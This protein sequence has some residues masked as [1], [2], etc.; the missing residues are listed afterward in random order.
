MFR[1]ILLIAGVCVL[2][3]GESAGQSVTPPAIAESNRLP[4]TPFGDLGSETYRF[5]FRNIPWDF[6]LQRFAEKANLTLD[7]TDLPPDGF[8]YVD[9]AE[10]TLA[11]ALDVINGYLLPRGYV[12]LRRNQFLVV[13]KADNPILPNMIPTVAVEDLEKFGDHELLRTVVPVKGFKPS[14]VAEQIGQFLGAHGKASPVDASESVLLQG[15]GKS[16]RVAVAVLESS[17]A[18]PANDE[19]V[20]RAF[21]LEN[22]LAADAE[23]QIQKLFGVGSNPY[24]ASLARRDDYYRRRRGGDDDKNRPPQPTPLL[25]NLTMNMKISSLARTNSLLVTAPPSAVTLV[26]SILESLDVKPAGDSEQFLDDS[27]P[28]LRVYTVNEADEDDVAETVNAIM[29]GVVINEDGRHDSVHIYATP[30]EHAEVEKLIRIIDQGGAGGGVEVIALYRNDPYMMSELLS[31]LFTNEDRDDRPVITAEPRTRSLVIRAASSQMLEIKKTLAAYGET[32]SLRTLTAEA[33]SSR[34][35]KVSVP[36]GRAEW[37]ARAVKDMLSGDPEFDNPIRVI[38]PG[39]LSNKA[40]NTPPSADRGLS[41]GISISSTSDFRDRP[42]ETLYASAEA[43][44]EEARSAACTNR[45]D[46]AGVEAQNTSTGASETET[47]DRPRVTIEVRD[48][49]LFLYSNDGTALDEIEETVRE[50]AREMPA[51]TNW[52][53]FYLRAA[54]AADTAEQLAQL[55][56]DGTD[57]YVSI[58]LPRAGESVLSLGMQSVRIIP[59]TRTNA[60]YISGPAS[61]IQ[62]ADRFLELLDTTD[63][64]ISL[65]DRVPRPIP[66]QHADVNSVAEMVKELYKDYIVD[67]N[68]RRDERRDGRRDDSSD[69]DRRRVNVER[70]GDRQQVGIRLTVAVDAQ[71]NELIV[72]CSEPLY[73]QIKELVEERDLAA[74]ESQPK[75]Q[76]VRIQENSAE[77]LLD[78][79]GNMS[80]RI[81]VGTTS[82]STSR[83]SSSSSYRGYPRSSSSSRYDPR[84]RSR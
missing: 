41:R 22:I 24:A 72:S 3:S 20:F 48:G 14:E 77:M 60:L 49:E 2:S 17:V 65:K 13:L 53:V 47:P 68:A 61:K 46:R 37:I 40:S 54:N 38:V 74:V 67:P 21:P 18:P 26:E 80:P 30:R 19:L 75:V 16:L 66:V 83:S 35:R 45:P 44:I 52:T 4:Q 63:I 33:R 64:P 78:S 15:F 32:G 27:T 51:R 9:N 34:F 36:D 76:I 59:D 11:E 50:L 43:S 8:N 58:G 55:L 82:T 12:L 56:R 71:S 79:L 7:L 69:R 23:R 29:P 31:S 5:H 84:R 70:A 62:E 73:R 28:V 25:Q 1:F 57:P 81:T 39:E 6:V 42:S 10:H